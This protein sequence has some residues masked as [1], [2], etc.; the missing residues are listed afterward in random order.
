M[1]F[2][3]TVTVVRAK[4]VRDRWDNDTLDWAAATRTTVT[5]VL[6][7]PTSQ[8]EDAAG[9]RVALSSGWR[10]YSQPGTDVDLFATDR[11][12]WRAMSLE[13]IGEVARWPHPLRPGAV[14][15]VEAELRKVTG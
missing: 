1:I 15:H 12:E 8:I 10:L 9:N 13:V 3:D 14:H 4:V 6:V 7:M 5:G 11:V 2:A